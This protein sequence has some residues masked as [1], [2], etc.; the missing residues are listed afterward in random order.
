MKVKINDM[1][2]ETADGISLKSLLEQQNISSKGTAVAVNGQVIS[3]NAY[4]T[5]V[6]NDGDSLLIITAFYGG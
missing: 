6:I 5:T 3:K 2:I 4:E 1:T